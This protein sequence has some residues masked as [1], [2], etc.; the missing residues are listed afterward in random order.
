MVVTAAVEG[1]L[2][3]AVVQRDSKK[4]AEDLERSHAEKENDTSKMG[5]LRV[6]ITAVLISWLVMVSDLDEDAYCAP[7]LRRALRLPEPRPLYHVFFA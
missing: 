7:E 4:R 1:S 6:F 2:D 3:E 5:D